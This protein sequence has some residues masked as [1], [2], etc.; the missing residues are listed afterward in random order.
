MKWVMVFLG[1]LFIAATLVDSNEEMELKAEVNGQVFEVNTST[2]NI[3]H[4]RIQDSVKV[5][6][7]V[8]LDGEE[9][10]S[11]TYIF[12][13]K[14]TLKRGQKTLYVMNYKKGYQ[15]VFFPET[16]RTMLQP[17]DLIIFSMSN[18]TF[19]DESGVHT[20]MLPQDLREL[21]IKV[22]D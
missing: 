16:A 22:T 18:F 17:G 20:Q 14:I 11:T 1:V 10:S 19:E 12:T 5:N 6:L 21:T 13:Y 3:A 15:D 8:F 9:A 4:I 2:H 7:K